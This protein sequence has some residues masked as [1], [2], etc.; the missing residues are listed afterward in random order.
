MPAFIVPIAALLLGSAFL[1]LGSGLHGL[2]LPIRGHIEGFSATELGLVGAGWAVGFIGGCLAI[3]EAVR[4]VGHVRA[5][6]ATAALAA[7]AILLNIMIIDPI[8]WIVLRVLSG[9]AGAGAA[10]I[11]E[12]WLNERV[13]S[14]RRGRIFAIY[15]MTNLTASTTGQLLVATADPS[16]A[17]LFT[18]GAIF[19]CLALLPTAL[20]TATAPRPLQQVRPDLRGLFTASPVAAV[21][22]FL[23]GLDQGAFGSLGAVYA[24]GIGL[25]VPSVAFFMSAA[26]LGGALAQ[27]PIGRLSDRFD[28]RHVLAGLA[29]AGAALA[30]VL[31]VLPIAEPWLAITLAG[32]FGAMLYPMYPLAVAHANDQSGG[33]GFLRVA[34]GLLLLFG[35]GL[36]VGPLVAAF[37]MDYFGGG[38]LFVFLASVNV[39]I[40][41]YAVVRSR[42]RAAR[43]STRQPTVQNLPLSKTTPEL[44]ALD[45]RSEEPPEAPRPVDAAA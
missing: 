36:M 44:L 26:V 20:S 15:M 25:P 32:V 30:V 35:F 29:L 23:I 38:G 16:A 24:Q 10:M 37:A 33:E 42:M 5:Y 17:T 28:R 11:V 2:I 31:A 14:E 27:L 7:I 22:A 40:A 34:G 41:V 3:P 13:T 1:M 18:L 45:P 19:Y 6:G 43:P 4:R 8:A 39:V 9:F 12:S 21:S